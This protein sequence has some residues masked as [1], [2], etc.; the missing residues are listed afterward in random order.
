MIPHSACEILNK[1]FFYGLGQGYFYAVQPHILS[2][3]ANIH[4]IHPPTSIG[5][6]TNG[7]VTAEEY[8]K[9]LDEDTY[10]IVFQDGSIAYLECTFNG[11]VLDSY[12]F[13]YIP[14]PF[15]ET[16]ILDLPEGVPLADWL[17]MVLEDR[18]VQC[19][20]SVGALRFDCVRGLSTDVKDP[21]PVSHLTMMT[22]DCRIPIR[23]PVQ[24]TTFF[25]FIFDNF[26]RSAR[27]CWLK[28]S[29][30]LRFD[31]SEI[32]ITPEEMAIMHVNWENA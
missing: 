18:G 27:P 2:K 5:V 16:H 15:D 30:Y 13:I 28:F 32:T 1:F 24:I 25:H 20:K 9:I 6:I 8:I 26:Q 14:S 11:S 10:S 12:R 31:T 22:G 21:H 4:R 17:R 29:S 19:L 3:A 7:G 23:G